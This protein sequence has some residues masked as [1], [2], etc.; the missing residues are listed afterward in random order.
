MN[1]KNGIFKFNQ[2]YP[3]F[4]KENKKGCKNMRKTCTCR[5][6]L[7]KCRDALTGSSQKGYD[8]FFWLKIGIGITET[9]I[10]PSKTLFA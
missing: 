10:N 7:N 3:D 2:N 6:R 8:F 9:C 4:K 5:Q 1:M